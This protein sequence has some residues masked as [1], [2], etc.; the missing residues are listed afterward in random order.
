MPA[1][2]SNCAPHRLTRFATIMMLLRRAFLLFAI[3]LLLPVVHAGAAPFDLSGPILEVNI[4]RGTRTL[5][6]AQVPHLAVG[7]H[8]SIKADLPASQSAHYLLVT[9]FLSGS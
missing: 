3:D 6:A 1:P 4:T 9:A 8:I 7:D 2:H 5:P